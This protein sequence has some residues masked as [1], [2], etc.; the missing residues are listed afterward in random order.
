MKYITFA[1]PSYNSQE[2]LHHAVESILVAGNDVEILIV[3]DG[4]KDNTFHIA[5]EYEK[6]YPQIIKAI[7]QENGGHG[8]AVNTGLAHATGKYFKV[9][10]S[11][12]WVNKEALLEVLKTIKEL[13]SKGENLD[14][15]VSNFVYEK[16]GRKKKKVVDYKNVLPEGEIFSWEQVG[17]FAMDQYIIMHSV[18]YRTDL[19]KLCQL[20]LPKHT[21]YVDNIYVYFPLPY[22]RN[23]YYLNV[24]FYRYF[25]GR[26]DQ[27]V[28][29]KNMIARADQQIYVTKSMIDMYDIN[30]IMPKHLKE[31]MINYL[32][33]MMT[34]SSI[35]LIRSKT[36]ENLGKKREL[37]HF[38]KKKDLGVYLKI[39]YGI[40][41]RTMNLP[42]KSGRKI[43]SLVYTITRRIV[44]FN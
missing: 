43:S 42:G 38:L 30:R 29:E 18:I 9:V 3:N 32:A 41:G 1:I 4:S 35:I 31:Y 22:V 23:I 33:I 20:E 27:S 16:Q 44:G 28:N 11:D 25:I 19:L 36:E 21:F 26:D 13:E 12:D 39:R 14:M 17:R 2:Y 10:D 15:L 7:N 5:Y 8:S 37:W 24:D 40:L 34:V 6:K